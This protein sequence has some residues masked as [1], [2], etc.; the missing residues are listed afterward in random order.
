MLL[1]LLLTMEGWRERRALAVLV[2]HVRCE[3]LVRAGVR[4]HVRPRARRPSIAVRTCALLRH[5]REMRLSVRWHRG[6]ALVL[7]RH[8]T[9][10]GVLGHHR[11]TG[12]HLR[13]V[14]TEAGAWRETGAHLVH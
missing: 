14:R 3:A 5:V 12:A 2:L 6:V 7:W 9:A 1:R 10:G 8:E 13:H 4:H 11:C